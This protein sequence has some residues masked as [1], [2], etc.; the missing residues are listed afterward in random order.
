[1]FDPFA[2]LNQP[3]SFAVDVQQL[4]REYLSASAAHHPD[5]FADP[6]EQADAAERISLINQ[7]YR[8]LTDSEA[9]ADVLLKLL[10]GPSK[11]QD[12]SLPADLLEDMLEIRE[13]ME[14]ASSHDD[15]QT[16]RQLHE[17]GI[18]ERDA[19]LAKIRGYFAELEK[20]ADSPSSSSLLKQIRLELNALRYFERLIEQ[21]PA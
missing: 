13:V 17:R 2:I 18:A 5:R 1:M 20:S 21:T 16:L 12:K 4:R 6:M 8:V 11:E 15:Q 3:R 7:A 19:R 10:G 9:R 14:T